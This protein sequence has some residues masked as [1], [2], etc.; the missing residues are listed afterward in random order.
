VTSPPLAAV[1]VLLFAHYAELV[2]A[3]EA[4][5]Q[6]PLPATVADVVQRLRAEL[7]HGDRLPSRPLAAVNAHHAPLDTAVAAGDE[8]ALLPPLAGG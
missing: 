2:G 7:P 3:R 6:V 1:R 8:I 4:T 5:V